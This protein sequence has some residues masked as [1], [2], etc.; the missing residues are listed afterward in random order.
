VDKLYSANELEEHEIT[1]REDG[2]FLVDGLVSVDEFK[3][4][5]HVKK[6]PDERT[7]TF[8]TIGGFV[9]HK[10]SRI[11][12]AG[13]KFVFENYTFEVIDMDGNRIDKILVVPIRK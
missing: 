5:F 9:M 10:L 11:P 4:Y 2:S 6:V 13:D 12:T 3:E 1:K 8:H 7:G